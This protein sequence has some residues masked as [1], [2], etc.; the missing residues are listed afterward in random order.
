MV[1]LGRRGA[2]K[3]RFQKWSGGSSPSGGTEGYGLAPFSK[4]STIVR[5]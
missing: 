4:N 5:A 1:E 3:M 2:L